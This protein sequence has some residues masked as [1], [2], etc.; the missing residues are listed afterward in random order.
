VPKKSKKVVIDPSG[1][2]LSQFQAKF[3]STWKAIVD[4]P[5][6]QAGTQFLRNRK[7]ERISLL[8]EAEI[9]K[10][11]REY[12]ADLR[13]YLQ[14]ED[15]LMKLPEMTDFSLPFEEE[16][17]YISPEE[18]AER[19]QLRKKYQGEAKKQRYA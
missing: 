5:A 4:S 13:G 3:G 1:T 16:T 18:E 12:L 6:Y 17:E 8:S 19:E 2:D 7:M 9:E 11:G 10:N 15:E 14:H